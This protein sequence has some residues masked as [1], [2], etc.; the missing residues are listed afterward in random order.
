MAEIGKGSWCQTGV[1][2]DFQ[3]LVALKTPV[4]RQDNFSNP[5][6]PS[7]TQLAGKKYDGAGRHNGCVKTRGVK[8]GTLIGIYQ[9]Y[10]TWH[11]D[12]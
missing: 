6:A 11:H 12:L 9:N 8:L 3:R 10:L 4:D 5:V 2:G 7:L 1:E